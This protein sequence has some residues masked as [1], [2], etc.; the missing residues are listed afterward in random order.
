MEVLRLQIVTASVGRA[1]RSAINAHSK[2][3][4]SGKKSRLFL[5][6]RRHHL[7]NGYRWS[8]HADIATWVLRRSMIGSVNF[9]YQIL[10]DD[11]T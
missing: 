8:G 3:R 1:D 5:G 11:I 6:G 2:L 9:N 10:A 4:W 7:M